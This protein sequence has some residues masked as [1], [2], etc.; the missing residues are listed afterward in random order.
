[1]SLFTFKDRS[2]A[3]AAVESISRDRR[4]ALGLLGGVIGTT[5]FI[6]GLMRAAWALG[7]GSSSQLFTLG[8]GS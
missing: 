3:V 4:R 8:V 6:P 1:M 5:T 7:E 2:T